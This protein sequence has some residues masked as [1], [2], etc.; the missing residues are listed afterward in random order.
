MVELKYIQTRSWSAPVS[1]DTLIGLN[2]CL[3]NLITGLNE[4]NKERREY[5]N[6]TMLDLKDEINKRFGEEDVPNHMKLV[7]FYNIGV[8]RVGEEK[9][10]KI[11]FYEYLRE[12]VQAYLDHNNIRLLKH[13]IKKN[14]SL[15]GGEF[16]INYEMISLIK[17]SEEYKNLMSKYDF[18]EQDTINALKEY[19]YDKEYEELSL[20]IEDSIT[21]SNR[22]TYSVKGHDIV[23]KIDLEVALLPLGTEVIA[24][25]DN[26]I[27]LGE[28][29][30]IEYDLEKCFKE[31]FLNYKAGYKDFIKKINNIRIKRELKEKE[32]PYTIEVKSLNTI[33]FS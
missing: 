12:G 22:T 28:I 26:K 5:L 7:L 18:L 21:K 9:M 19:E 29:S 3:E 32:T 10:K 1:D 20:T 13:V 23:K 11:I 27:K 6:Q 30:I 33:I 8:E 4:L 31:D 15:R 14:K 25:I 17:E 2:S 24:K 16:N